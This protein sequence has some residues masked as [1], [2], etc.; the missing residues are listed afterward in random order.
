KR[1]SLDRL[2]ATPGVQS[3]L[4]RAITQKRGATVTR[5]RALITGAGAKDGIGFACARLLAEAGFAV[6][7]SATTDR[8]LDRANELNTAGHTASGHIGDLT[9]TE[10]VDHLL[11]E[12]GNINVL[13]NNAGMGTQAKPALEKRLTQIA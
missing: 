1:A 12:L 11:S 6:A 13:V 3:W 7:L 4:F 2:G 10:D 9:Q 5:S 8:V